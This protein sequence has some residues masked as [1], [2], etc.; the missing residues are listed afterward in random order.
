MVVIVPEFG[1]TGELD[2]PTTIRVNHGG[3]LRGIEHQR[4]RVEEGEVPHPVHDAPSH[5]VDGTAAGVVEFDPF[6]V[7]ERVSIVGGV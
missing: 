6:A 4:A 1:V 5:E 2:Q 3:A 7:R